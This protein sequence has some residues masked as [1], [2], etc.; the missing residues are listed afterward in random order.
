MKVKKRRRRE[1]NVMK[2]TRVI[3]KKKGEANKE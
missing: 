3:K 1:I 2:R